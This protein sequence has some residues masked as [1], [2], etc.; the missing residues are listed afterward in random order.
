METMTLALIG[1]GVGVFL[2]FT[3]AYIII[4]SEIKPYKLKPPKYWEEYINGKYDIK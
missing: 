1:F 4:R 2:L 3:M